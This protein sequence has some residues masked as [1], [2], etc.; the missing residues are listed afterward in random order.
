MPEM[1]AITDHI[2]TVFTYMLS[3]HSVPYKGIHDY[4]FDKK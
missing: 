1:I 4:S 3:H 2:I